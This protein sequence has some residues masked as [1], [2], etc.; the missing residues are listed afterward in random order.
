MNPRNLE[1]TPILD[2][3]A[4]AIAQLAASLRAATDVDASAN[5][6]AVAG[7][8]SVAG[9]GANAGGS[10]ERYLQAAHAAISERIRPIYTIKERQPVSQTMA[11][12]CG[13]CS[14]R[15]AC[16]EAVARRGGIGTRVRALWVA[17]RFWNSRFP[18]TRAFIPDRVLLGWPQFRV[19]GEWR[20]IEDIFGPLEDRGKEATAFTNDGETLFEAVRSTAV[21]FEGRTRVCASACDL[22]HF[23]I[24]HGG[25]FDT[26]D[27]LFARLGSLED[28]WRGRAFERLYAGR[29]SR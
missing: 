12:R 10:E 16:L 4:P 25:L 19:D 8:G 20:G 14:Q 6:R 24:D 5:T 23:V 22:S 11:R 27:E 1:P 3:D 17:G 7:A 18:L 28:T 29:S 15:L 9:A 26:R 21:D 2:Y 13:S